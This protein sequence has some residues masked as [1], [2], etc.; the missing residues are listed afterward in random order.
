MNPKYIYHYTSLENANRIIKSRQLFLFDVFK[1]KDRYEYFYGGNIVAEQLGRLTR[2]ESLQKHFGHNSTNIPYMWGGIVRFFSNNKMYLEL[3]NSLKSNSNNKLME[4]LN[5]LDEEIKYYIISFSTDPNNPYLWKNYADNYNG[6]VLKFDLDYIRSVVSNLGCD[7]INYINDDESTNTL[8]SSIL[9]KYRND[10]EFYNKSLIEL[11]RFIV[12]SKSKEYNH[13]KEFR[14]T[15][16]NNPKISNKNE[17]KVFKLDGRDYVKLFRFEYD[18][19]NSLLE[20]SIGEGIFGD[21]RVSVIKN[22]NS[23]V[24]NILIL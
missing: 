3:F 1:Q 4:F 19:L 21:E 16:H 2:V 13:E 24:P 22:L 5:S 12:Y 7:K 14:I 18:F 11:T 8:I 15:L 17:N 10:K 6:V 20:I 23:Q 9:F